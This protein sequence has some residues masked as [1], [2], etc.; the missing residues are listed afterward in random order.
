MP[1]T[2]SG[3]DT[4]HALLTIPSDGDPRAA[5]SVN[6]PFESLQD[7]TQYFKNRLGAYRL[8]GIFTSQRTDANDP[9]IT[10]LYFWTGTSYVN[11]YQIINTGFVPQP[12]GGDLVEF[13]VSGTV[14]VSSDQSVTTQAVIKARYSQNNGVSYVDVGASRHAVFDPTGAHVQ[15]YYPF[16]LSGTFITGASAATLA[17]A[18]TGKVNASANTQTLSLVGDLTTIV[19]VWRAP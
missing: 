12:A 18:L 1:S 19:R 9:P 2:Y 3:A 5:A 8:V 13:S 15:L 6:V 10:A 17:L 16:N 7:N 4:F 14:S 11:D